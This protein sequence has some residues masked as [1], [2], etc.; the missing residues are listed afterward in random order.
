MRWLSWILLL[1]L[2]VVVVVFFVSNR[3]VITIDLWPLGYTVELPVFAIVLVSLMFGFVLGG[4]IAWA[5]GAKNRSKARSVARDATSARRE[6]S[7]LRQEI[8]KESGMD[9]EKTDQ[10]ISPQETIMPS[11]SAPKIP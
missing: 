1:P 2:C 3:T 4:M 8:R 11:L 7:A 10:K 9:T 5:R 6:L